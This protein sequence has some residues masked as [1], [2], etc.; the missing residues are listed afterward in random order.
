MPDYQRRMQERRG[1]S[2]LETVFGVT[3]LPSDTWIREQPDRIPPEQFS[4]IFNSAL[5][6]AE[7]AG[8][9]EGY[10]VL[11]GGGAHSP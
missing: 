5:E 4:G 8:L 10:R 2:N 1:R 11:D 6:I 9:A 3:V 7:E